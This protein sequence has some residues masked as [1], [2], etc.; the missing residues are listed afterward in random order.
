MTLGDIEEVAP[1]AV[2]APPRQTELYFAVSNRSFLEIEKSTPNLIAT[3]DDEQSRLQ[4]SKDWFTKNGL[5]DVAPMPNFD[6]FYASQIQN[7]LAARGTRFLPERYRGLPLNGVV[8]HKEGSFYLFGPQ[9]GVRYLASVGKDDQ[10][11]YMFDFINFG[12][13][14]GGEETLPD[15]RWAEEEGS[16]LFIASDRG[17]MAIDLGDRR[18]RWRS[19]PQ[20]SIGSNFALSNGIIY[21]GYNCECDVNPVGPFVID[22]GSGRVLQAFEIET[23][24]DWLFV[25]GQRLYL[26]GGGLDYVFKITGEQPPKPRKQAASGPYAVNLSS[27]TPIAFPS[28]SQV[29]TNED[30]ALPIFRRASSR[31]LPLIPGREEE[32][33]QFS[34][35]LARHRSIR[36]LQ[37]NGLDKTHPELTPGFSP[38]ADVDAAIL[39]SYRVTVWSMS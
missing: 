13:D 22:A 15:I 16:T 18:V 6:A 10:V 14:Q 25:K 30:N 8:D 9:Q 17:L 29:T 35:E 2:D 12:E 37:R 24:I 1:T 26:R 28:Y 3:A 38:L 33:D 4:D 19:S 21:S 32:P 31:P 27:V 5:T 36:W 23:S 7:L 39:M 20:V 34:R 11:R